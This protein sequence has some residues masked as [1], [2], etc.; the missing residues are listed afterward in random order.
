MKK[1]LCVL[2]TVLLTTSGVLSIAVDKTHE[3]TIQQN[4]NVDKEAVDWNQVKNYFKENSFETLYQTNSLKDANGHPL[5]SEVVNK[6]QQKSLE[7]VNNFKNKNFNLNQITNYL[8]T[9]VKD[10][11]QHFK[12]D[13]KNETLKLNSYSLLQTNNKDLDK[14]KTITNTLNAVNKLKIVNTGIY[15]AATIAEIAAAGFW[16][17]A[18]WFGLSVPWAIAATTLGA[19]LFTVY[20]AINTFLIDNDI[21]NKNLWDDLLWAKDITFFVSSVSYSL[22]YNTAVLVAEGTLTATSWAVPAAF[23]AIGVFFGTWTWLKLYIEDI[24]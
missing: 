2:S 10:F 22:I 23:A 14:E 3:S 7:Y 5:T 12:V 21:S 15:T 19:A 20:Y 16:A 8:K 24:I 1:L 13:N 6:V 11:D 18:W 17:A 9:N 4:N